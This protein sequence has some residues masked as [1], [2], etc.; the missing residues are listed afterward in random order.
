MGR[1][2]L[3]L[4]EYVPCSLCGVRL[5][6]N[7]WLSPIAAIVSVLF[8]LFGLLVLRSS[9]VWLMVVFVGYLAARLGLALLLPLRVGGGSLNAFRRFGQ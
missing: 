3:H 7:P 5:V 4:R 1:A 6:A 9:W 2:L 8:V